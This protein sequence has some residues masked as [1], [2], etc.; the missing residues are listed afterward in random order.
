MFASI[1]WLNWFVSLSESVFAASIAIALEADDMR[2]S[3]TTET[4][5]VCANSRRSAFAG[6]PFGETEGFCD[7]E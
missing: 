7:E 2:S 3:C 6:V 4:G 1:H 5:P